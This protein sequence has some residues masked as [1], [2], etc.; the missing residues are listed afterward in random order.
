MPS[1]HAT[2]FPGKK[3]NRGGERHIA[4]QFVA[5]APQSQGDAV[6]AF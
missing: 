1:S 2:Q 5:A 6:T 4:S 3:Y